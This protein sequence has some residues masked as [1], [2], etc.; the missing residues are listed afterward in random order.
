MVFF[1]YKEVLTVIIGGVTY[2]FVKLY[3]VY[4]KLKKTTCLFNNSST[5]LVLYVVMYD[6]KKK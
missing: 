5:T 6:L 1:R 3:N 4:G 2:V